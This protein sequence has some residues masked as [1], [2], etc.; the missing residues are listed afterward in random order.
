M[1][2][3]RETRRFAGSGTL[4]LFAPVVPTLYLTIF[5]YLQGFAA[6]ASADVGGEPAVTMS[7]LEALIA[8]PSVLATARAGMQ[9]AECTTVTASMVTELAQRDDDVAGWVARL[10]VQVDVA[11]LL[12]P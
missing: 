1:V 3:W 7:D 9:K 10:P 2:G 6:V 5:G 4:T 12:F 11:R 8:D